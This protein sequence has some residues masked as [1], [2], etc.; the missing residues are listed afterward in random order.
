MPLAKMAVLVAAW[1]QELL[2]NAKNLVWGVYVRVNEREREKE[3]S[4]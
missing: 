3:I 1:R 4:R 2:I